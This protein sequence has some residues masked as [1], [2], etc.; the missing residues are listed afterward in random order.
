M[1]EHNRPA[2]LDTTP[3]KIDHYYRNGVEMLKEGLPIPVP[4]EH[5]PT[6]T[7]MNALDAAAN[8]VRN[9]SGQVAR[10]EKDVIKDPKTGADIHRLLSVV[11][12]KDAAIGA[13]IKEGSLRWASPW[14]SSFTDGKGRQWNE[15]VAHLA[16]TNRPRIHEQHPFESINAALSVAAPKQTL[17]T[18]GFYLPRAGRLKADGKPAFPIAFSL[19]TGVKLSEDDLKDIVPDDEDDSDTGDDGAVDGETPAGDATATAIAGEEDI[20][21]MD[22]DNSGDVSFEELIPHLL[23]MHGIHVPA[24]G[25]GKEFLQALVQGLLASAKAM[26]QTDGGADDTVLGDAPVDPMADPNKTKG[27]ITQDSPPMYMSLQQIEKIADPE[28]KQMAKII[29]S[30]Q[31]ETGALRKNKLDEAA[32]IRQRRIENV[33][34]CV[35]PKNRDKIIQAAAAPGAQ[36]S[37]GTDGVVKDPMATM[38]DI[39]EEELRGMPELLKQ[40][41]KFNVQAQPSDGVLSDEQAQKLADDQTRGMQQPGSTA[42]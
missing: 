4:L 5:Q 8:M 35:T 31:G 10:Y 2:V 41:A 38:L 1:D 7:P 36:L 6:A 20:A 21:A 30:L 40:G 24:G 13:K 33:C 37:M 12:I 42:A 28:K 15:V 22:T 23:E 9:N 27:P 32:A 26:S 11:D 3:E 16:I 17:P 34:K 25:K 14:I 19:M 29:F 39:F 18:N